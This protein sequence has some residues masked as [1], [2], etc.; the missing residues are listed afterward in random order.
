MYPCPEGVMGKR[1]FSVSFLVL[2][3]R[4][5]CLYVEFSP[6]SSSYYM[7]TCGA[8]PSKDSYQDREDEKCVL[9]IEVSCVK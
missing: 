6:V 9:S 8:D 1:K 3:K 5:A 4:Q 7:Y 2:R